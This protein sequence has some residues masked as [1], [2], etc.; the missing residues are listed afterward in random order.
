MGQKSDLKLLLLLSERIFIFENSA[1]AAGALKSAFTLS[2]AFIINN[3]ET[4][5]TIQKLDQVLEQV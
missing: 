5:V 2:H 1:S 3:P 4:E